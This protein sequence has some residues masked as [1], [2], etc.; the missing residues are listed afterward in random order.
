MCDECI[1]SLLI[2]APC[3][4]LGIYVQLYMHKSAIV[5]PVQGRIAFTCFSFYPFYDTTKQFVHWGVYNT[6]LP[7]TKSLLYITMQYFNMHMV[8]L[9]VHPCFFYGGRRM[10]FHFAILCYGTTKPLCHSIGIGAP[11]FMF[12]SICYHTN[13]THVPMV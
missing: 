10:H 2:P 3:I 7:C 6:I 12:V 1:F 11:S 9:N 8:H 5:F 4:R 13:C